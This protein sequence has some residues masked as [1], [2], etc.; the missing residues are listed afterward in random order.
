M[1]FA[2]EAAFGTFHFGIRWFWC[3]VSWEEMLNKASDMPTMPLPPPGDYNTHNGPSTP[4]KEGDTDRPHRAS[5]GKLRGRSK[6]SS[7][8]SP[9]GDNE[10]ESKYRW[11]ST[12]EKRVFVW[13]LDET[14]IIFHS[15]LTGTFA[16]RYGKDTTTS[17]RIGLMMEEMIFNLADTH[18]FFNDL[19]DCDQIH[20]DDVSSDDNG[21]DLR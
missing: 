1:I 12:V 5:D 10:I 16:S 7:D 15:L 20:V 18:L 6:R 4:A 3:D 13:D 17:V 14:I 21:Q 19:E 11:A 2:F 9:A 8:P